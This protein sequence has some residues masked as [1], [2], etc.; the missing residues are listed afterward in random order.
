LSIVLT[1]AMTW[2]IIRGVKAGWFSNQPDETYTTVQSDGATHT[3]DIYRHFDE[4][5]HLEAS[6]QILHTRAP[7]TRDKLYAAAF[8]FPS[9]YTKHMSRIYQLL[10]CK[11]PPTKPQVCTLMGS[12]LNYFNHKYILL[13]YGSSRKM[14]PN[15]RGE[16]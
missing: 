7:C 2:C 5:F 8:H 6:T 14:H 13:N 12:W 11:L 3:W 1:G 9:S 10:I 15:Y 16:T 4:L